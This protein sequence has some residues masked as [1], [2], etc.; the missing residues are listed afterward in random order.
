MTDEQKKIK[1]NNLLNYTIDIIH[2]FKSNLKETQ[3]EIINE[4][5]NN[6]YTKQLNKNYKEFSERI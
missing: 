6:K 1:I 4:K 5:I 2:K 3:P